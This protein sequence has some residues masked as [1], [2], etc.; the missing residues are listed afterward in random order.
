[1]QN[2]DTL[3]LNAPSLPAGGGTINGLK[4]DMAGAGPDGAVSL[5]V[6]LPIS[7]GRG[8]APA[9]TL[10]Y[11]SRAGNGPFG[12][13]WDI[14]LAAIRRRTRKG[15]PVY[16]DTDEFTGPDG[17]VL[18]PALTSDGQAVIRTADTLINAKLSQ[19]YT[20]RTY[21][22]RLERD[23]SCFEYWQSPASGRAD[24][25]VVYSPDGQ[26]HLL[27]RNPQ[28]RI[29]HPQQP[30]QTAVWLQESSVSATGEQIY[31]QYRSED[32]MG[33]DAAEKTAHPAAT[34]QRY[35]VAVYYGNRHAGRRLPALTEIPTENT[36]LF[37]LTLDYGER[38]QALATAPIWHSP[39]TG[40]WACRQDVFSDYGY[41]FELRTRRLC[42]QVLLFHR[43]AT[44]AGSAQG[45]DTPA[46]ISC[47]QLT[48]QENPSISTLISVQQSAYAPDGTA[49]TL[50]PI[51]FGWQTFTPPTT[52]AWQPQNEGGHVNPL[53]PYQW[54]DLNGEGLAGLLY[55]DNGAWWYRS[56]IRVHKANQPNAVS[57]G[58]A[59]GLP[60]LPSLQKAGTL[61]DLNGDGRLQWLVTT[62]TVAGHYDRTPEGDWL[63]FT[64]LSALP[65]EYFH[66][67]AQ[68]ADIIGAGLSDMVLIGPRSV[69]L[70]VG[71]GA[72]WKAGQPVMQLDGIT[73]PV[74]GA[75]ARTLVAF[76]DLPGSGQQHLVAVTADGVRYW[77]NL[78]HGHFGQPITVPGFHQP[79]PAFHP[80]RVF[81]A[82]IDGSGTTDLI[83]VHP[84][85]LA[86][87]LNQS[88]NRFAP[89]FSVAL[90]EQV[91]YDSTSG[92]QVADIQGLGFASLLLT[93]AHPTPRHWV[94]HLAQDKP[95]LL[96]SMNNHLGARHTL[97]YRS[98]AQFWLDE[99][100]AVLAKGNP[101]PPSYLP[102]ALHT[103]WRSEIEDDITGNRL[104]SQVR[105]QHGVWDGEE[106][107]F[108]GFGFVEVHDTDTATSRGTA[109]EVNS[110]T[111]TRR[112]FA[113][114]LPAVDNRLPDEYWQG[115]SAVFTRFSARFTTGSGEHETAFT[116]NTSTA[117]WLNRATKGLLLRSELYGADGS[118]QAAIPYTVTE[119]RPQVRL[120]EARG[121]M[122]VIWPVMVESRTYV[123]ERVS[124]DPQCSQTV[125][126][127][128][129]ENGLPLRQVTLNYPRR[130]KPAVNPYPDTLPTTLFASSDDD[131]QRQLR[132][133]L[134]QSRLHTL[135]DTV[136]G[137]WLLGVPDATR[138]DGFV[139]PASAAPAA[140]LTLEALQKTNGLMTDKAA[141]FAGQQQV[142]YLDVQDKPTLKPTDLPPKVAFT[143]TAVLDEVLVNAL[144]QD[145]TTDA[146]TR[147]GYQQTGYLFPRGPEKTAKLWVARQGYATYAS[148]EHF[149]LP[150]AY[151]N[152]LLTAPVTVTRD[153]HDC[154]VMQ[155]QDAASLTTRAEYD[156]RF[157]TP[158]KVTDANDNVHTITLD[159]L[160]RVITARFHGTEAGKQVGYSNKPIPLPTDV[161]TALALTAPLPVAQLMLYV[162][163][164]GM[165]NPGDAERLPP[166]ILT[167]TTDRY[168]D[169]PA[170][171]IRQQV[172]F[173]D[174]L[175]RLLQTAIR[176]APGE[177]W[178][179]DAN[180]ALVKGPDGKPLS[181]F[182]KFR[183]LVTGR[184][185]YDNKG[186]A[187]RTYQPY[188][189]NDWRYVS[190]DSAR[191]DLIADT[192]DYDPT[193]RVWQV[194]TAKGYLK[195]V[196]FTPWW[197][198][199]EDE[200]DTAAS[201]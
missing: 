99:K 178:Q 51:T 60:T 194:K 11:H 1:M 41:G 50:P 91:R 158:V 163:D 147:A 74:A 4:G 184:T 110:P 117:F 94:C 175:G 96:N 61:T 137:V 53:Q 136:K 28:A 66:P 154:V 21:R 47:L 12:I 43:L 98:S 57:W 2:S 10:N 118:Q 113:T 135:K 101:T 133:T 42:R 150:V 35:L 116:P 124:N 93:T 49:C 9:L 193:G 84:D 181:A 195:R 144:A 196:Y 36:W 199:R 167:L 131:Q 80:D 87:Y 17:E 179:R 162:P 191:T 159:A 23:F 100:A 3:Q 180:G 106:R 33:C 18:V 37:I 59:R 72:G 119:N 5:S 22:S 104:V 46:L 156:W 149:W 97:H 45:D 83:Y 126:L 127:A 169:D 20:V 81:L 63:H 34:A 79:A 134:Q 82:D 182:T 73:L 48:Y 52:P 65:T 153:P 171:Q 58:E 139:H 112:W 67:R 190:D 6:P 141:V 15:V 8:Y 27:G 39:G 172:T 62:P 71:T 77:P 123:Y 151:R 111:I 44:L 143:E 183:W 201:L 90:P 152:T 108:R 174:G 115:D 173:S 26:V 129:D 14:G 198:A 32:E 69:R 145:I 78:G 76:S 88:G 107:E 85:H 109:A 70:Y 130:P 176:Q 19:P 140:G 95:W 166:H 164:S 25:W 177:A 192:H 56:P 189:L 92:L 200:N 103:L 188:F 102:F 114:G 186:Q 120:I 125:L 29:S 54:V 146:L 64:P 185:E 160:G 187:I 24:F 122:P 31:Y 142:W 170:Q 16:N 161:N 89:P 7:A 121:T 155:Y 30:S 38:A 105:Y 148:A 75:D 55:R 86:I 197:V 132:L 40:A 68:L 128:S 13:G 165:K 168:D 157:L 138:N